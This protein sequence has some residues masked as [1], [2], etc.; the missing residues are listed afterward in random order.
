MFGQS[1]I[2]L[3]EVRRQD[4]RPRLIEKK[5]WATRIGEEIGLNT[6][7][8]R[9]QFPQRVLKETKIVEMLLVNEGE[10][11]Q[12]RLEI[13]GIN[14]R[15]KIRVDR[16][17]TSKIRFSRLNMM[18][19]IERFHGVVRRRRRVRSGIHLDAS[20]KIFEKNRLEPRQRQMKIA[21]QRI[22]LS[23][24][25][26]TFS[27]GF[28]ADSR[29][30]DFALNSMFIQSVAQRL[31]FIGEFGERLKKF[32]RIDRQR[33]STFDRIDQSFLNDSIL[34]LSIS[35]DEGNYSTLELFVQGEN[36]IPLIRPNLLNEII[37]TFRLNEMKPK[38][39][40]D[41][42]QTDTQIDATIDTQFI[43]PF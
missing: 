43:L 29:T 38:V 23:K 39:V 31:T 1:R 41:L 19:T 21:K 3:V 42:I 15:R 4:Q 32:F 2:F 36:G 17:K 26:G 16:L 13:E 28:T 6:S 37:L 10:D 33:F 5:P 30:K 18:N 11:R 22:E 35:I 40:G 8:G 20:R 24:A 34:S 9:I 14:G 27:I 12:D 25:T 7:I